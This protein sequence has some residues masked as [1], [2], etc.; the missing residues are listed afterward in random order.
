LS[1]GFTLPRNLPE[2]INIIR[3]YKTTYIETLS[4]YRGRTYSHIIKGAGKEVFLTAVEV[5]PSAISAACTSPFV[6]FHM[7]STTTATSA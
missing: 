4:S 2:N 3:V 7:L 1:T 5:W 6:V